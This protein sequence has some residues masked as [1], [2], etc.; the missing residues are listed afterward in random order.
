MRAY[1]R[2]WNIAT[3][4]LSTHNI[5]IRLMAL[6]HWEDGTMICLLIENNFECPLGYYSWCRLEGSLWSVLA[7]RHVNAPT[8]KRSQKPRVQLGKCFCHSSFFA[9][10]IT[11]FSTAKTLVR[12][13]QHNLSSKFFFV[14]FLRLFRPR[15]FLVPYQC[16]DNP[17]KCHNVIRLLNQI[18]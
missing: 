15:T 17:I 11:N 8:K 9:L 5:S 7:D 13:H 18:N 4:S 1:H 14:S 6:T 16:H 2:I 10:A 3:S 12:H